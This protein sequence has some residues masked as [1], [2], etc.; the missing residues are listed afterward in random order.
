METQLDSID[1]Y[2]RQ[3]SSDLERQ[4]ERLEEEMA[5]LE[6]VRMLRNLVEEQ[7]QQIDDQHD[8]LVTLEKQQEVQDAKMAKLQADYDEVKA[9]RDALRLKLSELGKMTNQVALKTESDALIRA[10]RVYMNI[11]RRKTVKKRGYIKMSI[12]ELATASNTTLP[13]DMLEE[14]DT[15]DDDT[16]QPQ[17]VNVNAGGIYV[18]Q[19]ETL[20]H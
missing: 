16:P 8:E 11:S 9:E 10:L 7:Q 20:T 15:F 14:L 18:Q 12:L 19:A 5:Q 13:A 17:Q 6:A 2:L 1:D 3:T 4:R